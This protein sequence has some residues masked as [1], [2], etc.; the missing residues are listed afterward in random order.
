MH[1]RPKMI[2]Q[3]RGSEFLHNVPPSTFPMYGS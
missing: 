2:L 1:V 3:E